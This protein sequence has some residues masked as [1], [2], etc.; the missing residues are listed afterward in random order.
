MNPKEIGREA[1]RIFQFHLPRHWSFR[2]QEDQE[3]YGI[4]A[5]IEI[6]D[7][8]DHATGFIFKVQIKG[9]KSVNIIQ[10]GA[11][12]SFSHR[13][14]KLKY[15]MNQI[16]IPVILV[17]VDV[18]LKKIFWRSLQDDET[19][20]EILKQ[21]IDK[22]QDKVSIHLETSN[23]LPEKCDELLAAV[24]YN[25]NWLRISALNRMSGPIDD[26]CKKSSSDLLSEMLEKSKLLNF[27]IYGEKF[28]RLYINHNFDELFSTAK[29]VINS[30]T[31]KLE[32]RFFAGLYIERVYYE[33]IDQKTETFNKLRFNLFVYLIEIAKTFKAPKYIRLHSL[34]LI[35]SLRLKF[36]VEEDYHLYVSE[37]LLE[38]D[39]L[40]KWIV[41][42]SRSKASLRA[43]RDVGKV[44]HLMNRIILSG[45][46]SI[47]LDSL[48][49][50]C[51]K[52]SFFAYRL[53]MDGFDEQ[54]GYIYSWIKLCIDLSIEVSKQSSQE[55]S[56]AEIIILNASFKINSDD[57]SKYLE[58]SLIMAEEIENEATRNYARD[59]ISKIRSIFSEDDED[60]SPEKEI[61]FF[62]N[63]AKALGINVDN[64][65][66]EIGRIISQGLKDYNPE[67]ILNNC[68]H[69]FVCMSS[70]QGIPAKI[71][72]I[73]SAGIKWIHCLK[74]GH[75]MMGWSL[76]DI[77]QSP[78][79]EFGF[80]PEYCDGCEFKTSRENNWK[81]SSKWQNEEFNKYKD[82]LIK[83][84]LLP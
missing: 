21:A 71:V 34:M 47:L 78:I 15:Y 56:L 10:K 27:H 31:E 18:T 69:L 82:I 67:R 66:D 54:A 83:K 52:I 37:K 55:E 80:K 29:S 57:A 24:E 36:S 33:K 19:L 61:D 59:R 77:Y 70:S 22:A 79:K 45:Y 20:R 62:Y 74:K 84:N 65:E 72:G 42:S 51:N 13:V 50:V 16:E 41:A 9:Q 49:R 30:P 17:V 53:K 2:V 23:T 4:D 81:W 58:E 25:M 32:A 12:A 7:S 76:D 8:S 75:S 60:T 40:T 48:P 64:P 44:I 35:R 28:E 6:I 5:E 68:T 39:H 3:D 63:R 38:N 73:P 43:A 14:E 11:V 1:G 26:L 46:N